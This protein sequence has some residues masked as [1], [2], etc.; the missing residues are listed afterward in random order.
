MGYK[1]L[2]TICGMAWT[3]GESEWKRMGDIKELRN[4]PDG[5]VYHTNVLT[6]ECYERRGRV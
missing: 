5:E 4:E 1:G 3:E 2:R 6:V